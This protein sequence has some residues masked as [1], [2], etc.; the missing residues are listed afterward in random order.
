MVTMHNLLS[1]KWWNE[2]TIPVARQYQDDWIAPRWYGLVC[3]VAW[4]GFFSFV[5]FAVSKLF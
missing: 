1:I 4:T 2:K 5:A 3:L